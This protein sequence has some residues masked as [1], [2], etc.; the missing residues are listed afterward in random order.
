MTERLIACWWISLFWERNFSD[1]WFVWLIKKD[2]LITELALIAIFGNVGRE[3]K[4]HQ[5]NINS[6]SNWQANS[7]EPKL[8]YQWMGWVISQIGGLAILWCLFI[9]HFPST[10]SGQVFVC[11]KR[12]IG[13]WT[14]TAEQNYRKVLIYIDSTGFLSSSSKYQHNIVLNF[15]LKVIWS[16]FVKVIQ[17]DLPKYWYF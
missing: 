6:H 17:I 7:L 4:R 3:K 16:L 2:A 8:W 12:L 9:C 5:K 10:G 15:R 14:V 11:E 1:N 13:Q